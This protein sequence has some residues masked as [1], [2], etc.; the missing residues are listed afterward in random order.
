MAKS[1]TKYTP[2]KS[3]KEYVFEC[4]CQGISQAK[5]CEGLKIDWKTFHKNLP[6]FSDALKKGEIEFNKHVERQVP[7]VVNTLLKR[8]MGYEVE[9]VTRKQDGEVINGQLR[10]GKITITK[11]TKHIQP[12]DAAIFFYL[13]NR[14]KQN[15]INPMKLEEE[16]P[17][18]RGKIL[19]WIEELKKPKKGSRSNAS[20]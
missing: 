7:Q 9:E 6:A 1:G 19:D 5:M 10:D 15:W 11:V 3:D 2:S 13:C 4:A 8:C 18:D 17:D 16:L 14:S 12:S 20:E